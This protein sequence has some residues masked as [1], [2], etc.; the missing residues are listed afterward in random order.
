MIHKQDWSMTG[1]LFLGHGIA[2]QGDRLTPFKDCQHILDL[3][4]FVITEPLV[5]FCKSFRFIYQ[6]IL[7]GIQAKLRLLIFQQ[8]CNQRLDLTSDPQQFH[9]THAGLRHIPR[10]GK[11]SQGINGL[12]QLP[13]ILIDMTDNRTPPVFIIPG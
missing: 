8:L 12:W 7:D 13:I 6:Q 3:K 1:R 5:Q 11:P 10:F 9:T 2:V 4:V